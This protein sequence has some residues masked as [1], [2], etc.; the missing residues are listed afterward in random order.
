[1]N[2]IH[3]HKPYKIVQSKAKRYAAH[4]NIPAE[5]CLILPLRELG[6]DVSCMVQWR[7]ES[8]ELEVKNGVMI[9][10]GAIEPI[11]PFK[12]DGLYDLFNAIRQA[13]T[14]PSQ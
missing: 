12:D 3:I 11:D 2:Y 7:N 4:Y 1:M 5:R 8:N 9:N 14:T 13:A 6:D 10:H